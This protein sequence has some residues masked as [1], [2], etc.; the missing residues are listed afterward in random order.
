M[1]LGRALR[2][3]LERLGL[4]V[5]LAGCTSAVTTTE[6][7]VLRDFDAPKKQPHTVSVQVGGGRETEAGYLPQISNETFAAALVE[8]IM[9]SRTFSRVIQGGRTDY[10][11]QVTLISLDQP[12]IG[13]DFTVKMEAAWRLT[14]SDTGAVVWREAIGSSSTQT[15]GD[16]FAA[17]TRVRLA[18]EGAARNNIKE[19]LARIVRLD[20]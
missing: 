11:L 5:W 2:L 13:G 16:T 20:L 6:G 7:I 1:T 19:G 10:L 9:T 8:S 17:V 12:V 15:R 14:R 18:T 4:V 3:T